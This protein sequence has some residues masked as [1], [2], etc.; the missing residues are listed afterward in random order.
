ML[1]SDAKN[2]LI[3]LTGKIVA[4]AFANKLGRFDGSTNSGA[5]MCSSEIALQKGR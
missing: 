2:N 3:T 1:T 5:A 4:G